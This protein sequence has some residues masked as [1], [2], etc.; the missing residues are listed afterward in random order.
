VV[1]WVVRE[2]GVGVP[3]LGR[4]MVVSPELMLSVMVVAAWV[5]LYERKY[6]AVINRMANK[7][8]PPPRR[9]C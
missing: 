7:A 8:I 5:R 6:M 4:V 3:D 1:V 9:G 2:K